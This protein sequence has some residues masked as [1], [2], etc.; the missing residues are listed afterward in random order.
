MR[1][2]FIAD[3]PREEVPSK[4]PPRVPTTISTHPTME[5]IKKCTRETLENIN[6]DDVKTDKE[7]LVM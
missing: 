4:D 2:V 6:D 1:Y 7:G 5:D 3:K